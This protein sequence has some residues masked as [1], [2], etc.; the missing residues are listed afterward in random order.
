M[1]C[2]KNFT[3]K[4]LNEATR[5]ITGLLKQ[6]PLLNSSGWASSFYYRTPENSLKEIIA[7]RDAMP[8][9]HAEPFLRACKWI[10]S[11]MVPSDKLCEEIS[12][13]GLKHLAEEEIGYIRNGTFIAA[14]I[15]CGFEF[16]PVTKDLNP[17]NLYFK[18]DYKALMRRL[19]TAV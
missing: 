9:D 2:S 7:E 6:Y 10:R 18:F 13:Y 14:A 15:H 8:V 1:T 12:S 3:V 4:E 16:A 19:A 11:S 5:V 17:Q